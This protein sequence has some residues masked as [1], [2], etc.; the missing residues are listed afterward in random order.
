MSYNAN[1]LNILKQNIM[2]DGVV[3]L[4]FCDFAQTEYAI[5]MS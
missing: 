5:N 4:S 3:R 2:K 1:I